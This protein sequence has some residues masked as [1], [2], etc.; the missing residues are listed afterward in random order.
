M[1]TGV[2]ISKKHEPLIFANPR[3]KRVLGILVV[4]AHVLGLLASV[5]AVMK[6][7]T[8]QGAIAWAVSLNTFP[9][10]MVPIYAVFGRQKFEGWVD[11][12]RDHEEDIGEL[13]DVLEPKLERTFS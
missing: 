3:V 8:A 4:F 10:V 9:Y 13:V 5:D 1:S 11:V 7:R 2:D 12:R 6:N